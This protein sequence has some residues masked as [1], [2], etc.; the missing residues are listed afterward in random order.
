MVVI[1]EEGFQVVEL[2]YAIETDQ[3]IAGQI[4]FD[5]EAD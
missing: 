3:V 4:Q 2:V 1:E 5:D